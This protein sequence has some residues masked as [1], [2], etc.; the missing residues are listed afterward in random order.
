MLTPCIRQ[1]KYWEIISSC[2]SSVL[3]V[4]AINMPSLGCDYI[5]KKHRGHEANKQL[6]FFLPGTLPETFLWRRARQFHPSILSRFWPAFHP[7]DTTRV[8]VL[9]SSST[10]PNRP[11]SW[12]TLQFCC[13]STPISNW[14]V[15]YINAFYK[16]LQYGLSLLLPA[17]FADSWYGWTQYRWPI[18]KSTPVIHVIALLPQSFNALPSKTHSCEKLEFII[19][20]LSGSNS[21]GDVKC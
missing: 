19:T 20:P 9:W 21:W 17:G 2:N 12:N 16:A 11:H 18:L 14:I 3:P 8:N 5:S 10:P 6:T 13:C 4:Y 1:S 7:K 15:C